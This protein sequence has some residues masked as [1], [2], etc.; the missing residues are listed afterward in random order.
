MNLVDLIQERLK[1]V[2]VRNHPTPVAIMTTDEASRLCDAIIV[3]YQEMKMLHL[4]NK[5]PLQLK[6]RLYYKLGQIYQLLE[7]PNADKK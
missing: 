7:L 4:D 5:M 1:T 2:G 6:R 3:A